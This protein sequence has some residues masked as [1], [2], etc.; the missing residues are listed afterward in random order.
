MF[1]GDIR[2]V[3]TKGASRDGGKTFSVAASHQMAKADLPHVM[4]YEDK[5]IKAAR[6]HNVQPSVVAAII[7]RETRGGRG[8]G[9]T[10]DGCGDGGNAF[11]LMQIDKRWHTPRG[12]WD[13]Q[14]HI[15]QGIEI[16]KGC[17]TDVANKFPYWSNNQKLKGSLAAYNMGAVNMSSSYD[18]VDGHTFGRDYANDV[19][20]RAQYYENNGF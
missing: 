8:Q 1:G 20:A 11:G 14:E 16:L 19:T 10:S 13:S 7:S 4:K 2:N 17:H 9:L 15:E 18:N 12:K 5:I 3:D 6:K